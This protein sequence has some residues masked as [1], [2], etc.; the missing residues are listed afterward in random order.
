MRIGTLLVDQGVL[1]QAQV[2]AALAVQRET[3]EPF[4]SVC[5]RLF[6]IAPDVIEGAWARQYERLVGAIDAKLDE[7]DP[8]A[9]ALVSRRQAWQFRLAPLRFEEGQLV[10]ATATDYLPRAVRFASAQLAVPVFF[11]LVS[12]ERLASHL[13]ARYPIVGMDL[14]GGKAAAA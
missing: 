9:E 1:T 13:A 10:V 14:E 8:A 12:P 4:G 11:V 7:I 6:G 3:S 2:D 5:E